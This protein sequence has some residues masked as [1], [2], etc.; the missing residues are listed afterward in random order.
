[1][2]IL[3]M[4]CECRKSME[5][6]LKVFKQI[7]TGWN[8]GGGRREERMKFRTL[9]FISLREHI[10]RSILD[11]NLEGKGKGKIVL[12][13]LDVVPKV[14]FNEK[15]GLSSHSIFRNCWC[16]SG[17]WSLYCIGSRSCD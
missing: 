3:C 11:T 5:A 7:L 13:S 17:T 4:I 16:G 8:G 2:S 15:G 9:G 6:C 1:M 12:G 14:R 10:E